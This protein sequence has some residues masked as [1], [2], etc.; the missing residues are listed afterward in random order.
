[1]PSITHEFPLIDEMKGL[2]KVTRVL[3]SAHTIE[4]P[5]QTTPVE[6]LSSK[7]ETRQ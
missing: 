3:Q 4:T 2:L 1:M 6:N 7:E 5:V